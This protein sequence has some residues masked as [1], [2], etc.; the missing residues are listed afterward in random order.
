MHLLKATH[1]PCQYRRI[2]GTMSGMNSKYSSSQR[3]FS[4]L[5][6]PLGIAVVFLIAAVIF[7]GW[8]YSKMQDYKNNVGAKVQAA[9]TTAKQQE[10]TA[11]DAVFTQ[12]YKLPLTSYTGPAA[13]SSVTLQY[14][15]TWSAYVVDDR[16]SSPYIDGYFYPH[17]L[18]DLQDSTS[19]FALRLQ[20]V[21]DAYSSVLNNLSDSVQ[22]GAAK[23]VPYRVPKVP[24][25][26]GVK[27]TGALGNGKSGTMVVIP[28]RN[29]TLKLWTEAPS[30][31]QDF[32]T[33]ILPNLS[34]AP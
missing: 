31:Q 13:Y 12:Q 22:S 19:A 26:I 4:I 34:F 28:L 21:Q 23:V 14:P 29:M 25:V 7:G 10:D 11:K 24:G 20:V 5:V 2:S 6:I 33:N 9:V 32:N 15:K 1:R 18:P 30:F 16:G 27:V 17:I 8:A 3:G